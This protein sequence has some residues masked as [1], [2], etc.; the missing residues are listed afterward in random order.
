MGRKKKTLK[1]EGILEAE[2]NVA[3]RLAG[4]VLDDIGQDVLEG[5]QKDKSSRTE[6]ERRNADMMKLALQVAEKKSSPWED[7]SN[8]KY[9]LLTVA[10]IQFASRV[11]LFQGADVVQAKVI[12]EDAD[13]E[14]M[15]RAIRIKKHMSYQ[16]AEQMQGW[17]DDNDRLLIAL[18]II[19]SMFKK[20]FYDP[21]LEQNRSE[22]VYPHDLVFDYWARD[23]DSAFRKTHILKFTPNQ[24]QERIRGGVYLDTD[25]DDKP[26]GDRVERELSE[27]V[28]GLSSYDDDDEPHKIL[29]QHRLL[30][31]DDDGYK[32]PY[33]VTVHKDS[34]KVLRIVP[35]YDEDGVKRQNSR[36][37]R[38]EPIE[39][40]TQFP[41]IPDPSGGNLG[42]GYGRLQG[43]LNEV[44]NTLI[45]QLIDAGTLANTQGGFLSK[46]IRLRAGDMNFDRMGEWKQVATSGV[47]LR[48]GI[49]PLPPKEP[50]QV[51][52]LLLQMIV[53]GAEKVGSI[54]DALVGEAPPPNTPATSTLATLEQGLRVFKAINKRLFK[55][56]TKEFKLLYNLNKKNLDTA[57]YFEVVGLNSD[58]RWR[59]LPKTAEMY[60]RRNQMSVNRN[61]YRAG[62][63][64]VPS[65]DPN[66][67]TGVE[68]AKKAEI[69]MQ[70]MG[71]GWP[72]EEVK[73]R[74][75]ESMRIE[76]P[77]PLLAPQ[78]PP[79]PPYQLQVAQIK[80]QTD[81]AKMQA[82]G[83]IKM[84]QMQLDQQRMA[85]DAKRL[86][87]D[88]QRMQM[89]MAKM[90]A[91][92]RKIVAEVG[93]ETEGQK[94]Q[95]E[96]QKAQE[97]LKIKRA[98]M[99]MELEMKKA[100]L[101]IKKQELQLK[102][103]EMQMQMD[104]QKQQ[105]E[106]QKYGIDQQ[107][108]TA[109]ETDRNKV[110]AKAM[111]HAGSMMGR[112]EEYEKRSK[113]PREVRR[114]DAGLLVSVGNTRVRRGPDGR[115]THIEPME[116]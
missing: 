20:T 46:G 91:E 7:A 115:A 17:E 21:V 27:D 10:A 13:G 57:E 50:S 24:I 29:E 12:G 80:A 66:A 5:F 6:W 14:K 44:T 11:D 60:Q 54:T 114:D 18:P 41:F 42:I 30:D 4:E 48:D 106:V 3:E 110:G 36:I 15:D 93:D 33:I 1:I 68:R 88:V 28:E 34:E 98:E 65:A 71:L 32:E 111:E 81:Q 52:F 47:S 59:L 63:G 39:Y 90:E 116:E 97:E 37:R 108:T 23:V 67:D 96:V 102:A 22:L 99:Q 112:L 2:D 25:L 38:I 83:Q 8:V 94:A 70:S 53:E 43:H 74:V 35:R 26:P 62:F 76:N 107:Q 49:F 31:L 105:L 79:A 84:A 9:P 103:A 109:L 101:E 51:L 77:E 19:G 85:L 78:P 87:A 64:V 40:F 92:I 45:N 16:L 104:M 75:V 55:A 73:K 69:L 56:Y 86:E 58:D 113:E 100:E 72:V 95:L 82:D 89:E 61:D